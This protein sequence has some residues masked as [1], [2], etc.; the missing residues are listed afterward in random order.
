MVSTNCF[1]S[2]CQSLRFLADRLILVTCTRCPQVL[3]MVKGKLQAEALRTY[4]FSYSSQYNSL[5]LD[6]LCS[7]F[8]MPEKKVGMC[9]LSFHMQRV[10]SVHAHVGMCACHG[11][12]WLWVWN[13]ARHRALS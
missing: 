7:M 11:V 13:D 10:R 12:A 4:L 5:S 8:E 2:A 6:Q 9:K 3:E 1:A